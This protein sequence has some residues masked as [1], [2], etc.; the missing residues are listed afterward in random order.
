MSVTGAGSVPAL[1]AVLPAA[2][3]SWLLLVGC[4]SRTSVWRLLSTG[5][6]TIAVSFLII[7]AATVTVS[8]GHFDP[9]TMLR[10]TTGVLP[11]A[12][13]IYGT[14]AAILTLL[15]GLTVHLISAR[16]GKFKKV[17]GL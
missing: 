3:M 1:A 7:V 5:Y 4:G 9:E 17:P 10:M 2:L 8:I 12:L 6:L 16:L 13:V 15:Y 11:R 14:G